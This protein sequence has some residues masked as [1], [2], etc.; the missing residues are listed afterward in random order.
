MVLV[1]LTGGIASG[2]S[3]VTRVFRSLGAC[4]I[5]ADELAREVVRPGTPAWDEVVSYFGEGILKKDG[6]IDRSQL[7]NIVFDD[8]EKRKVLN[9]IVHPRV[10]AEAERRRKEIEEKDP[11]AVVVF[12]VALLIESG[13]HKK[14]D[15]IVVVYTDEETQVRRLMERDRIDRESAI[16]RIRS[17]MPL[18]E[19]KGY[20]DYIVDGAMSVEELEQEI[21]RIYKELKDMA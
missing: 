3:T 15:R 19:K 5:D 6:S 7:A 20:A 13:A 10:F 14:M 1:G 21:E 18:I 16:K 11:V 9:S 8:P 4:V 2:K 12:D 17:Q